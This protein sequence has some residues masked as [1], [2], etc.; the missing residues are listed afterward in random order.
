[1][2]KDRI[3]FFY[4]QEQNKEAHSHHLS[5]TLKSNK[6]HSDWKGEGTLSLFTDDMIFH[7]LGWPKMLFGF[8]H[9]M[10][11]NFLANLIEYPKVKESESEVAQSCPTVCD[12]MDCSLPGSS[13]H[14]ILQARVLE[15]VAIS[16]SR[17]SSQPRD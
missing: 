7:V 1:M 5:S 4:D 11:W 13:L 17:G 9:K 15:W 8:F 3:I 16:F 2:K 14:G 6:R 12:P 10:L